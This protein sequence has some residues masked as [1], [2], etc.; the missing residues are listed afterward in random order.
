MNKD[1]LYFPISC[2]MRGCM[3]ENIQFMSANE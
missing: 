2:K 3:V 1:I